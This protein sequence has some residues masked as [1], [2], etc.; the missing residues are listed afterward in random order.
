MMTRLGPPSD[1]DLIG[2]SVK[3][4]GNNEVTNGLTENAAFSTG[5]TGISLF[6]R[7][8]KKRESITE[9]SSER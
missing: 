1:M 3:F 6:Q 4:V 9:K 7:F 8:R 2:S 5:P